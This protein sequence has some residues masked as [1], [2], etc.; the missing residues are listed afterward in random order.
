L[1]KE[2]R[3]GLARAAVLLDPSVP[4]AVLEMP[5]IEDAAGSL[6]VE[7]LV[8]EVRDAGDFERA[9]AA[10]A[11]GRAEGLV[12]VGGNL[13][14][15]HRASIVELAARHRLASIFAVRA[16]ADAGGL[17]TYGADTAESFRRAATYVDKIL[18]GARPGDLPIEQATKLQLVVNLRTARALGLKLPPSLL[19][20]ADEIIE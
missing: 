13:Y 2:A 4:T 15:A 5:F 18:R 1:L 12:T 17:M 3:P 9:F 11:K 10:M 14:F 16:F 8:A 19:A 7:L 20:R 6:K